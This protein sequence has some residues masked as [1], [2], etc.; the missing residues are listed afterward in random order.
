MR[1]NNIANPISLKKTSVILVSLV[2]KN[3][4]TQYR[5]SV[6]GILWTVLNPLLNMIVM[7]F[8][9]SN[10][11]GRNGISMDY[12]VYVL[13]G[14]IVFSLLRSSTTS[15]MKSIVNNYDLITKTRTP[16]M[17]FPLACVFTALSNLLFSL[18][19]LVLVMLFRHVP[20]YF[21]GVLMFLAWLPSLLLFV[22]GLSFLLSAFYVYFRD[23][24]HLYNV[25]LTLWL[26]LTP[27]F[28]SLETLKMP[29]E[30]AEIMMVNPMFHYVS[31]FRDAVSGIVPSIS[32]FA[33]CYGVGIGV[34]LVGIILF[35]AL[36]KKLV[37]YI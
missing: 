13:S 8:V 14:N 17:V 31:F 35:K 7:S 23:L 27:I 2:K 25:F 33:I 11:F 28:Y 3:I 29:Q 16:M 10:I 32:T 9:F 37:F 4:K 26:Y 24:S 15:A 20:F 21:M 34:L 22:S 12:P 19:A 30:Y 36:R 5:R 18:V 6:L 1:K